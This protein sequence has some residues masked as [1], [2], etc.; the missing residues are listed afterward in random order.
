MDIHDV[1]IY[2]MVCRSIDHRSQSHQDTYLILHTPN[3]SKKKLQS[4]YVYMQNIVKRC[5]TVVF[6][7]RIHPGQP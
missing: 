1:Y 5:K 3:Y 6:V 4:Y 2:I 7:Y